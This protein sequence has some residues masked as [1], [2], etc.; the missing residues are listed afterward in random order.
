MSVMT[1]YLMLNSR[2]KHCHCISTQIRPFAPLALQNKVCTIKGLHGGRE[3]WT[4]NSI[5][6]Q[7]LKP[8]Y[9]IRGLENFGY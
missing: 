4:V 9:L 6:I 7:S 5:G 2:H 8:S 1:T 3:H